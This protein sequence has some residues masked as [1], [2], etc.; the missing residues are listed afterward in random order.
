MSKIIVVY[1]KRYGKLTVGTNEI[2]KESDIKWLV[3]V[4]A[5]L[6]LFLFTMRWSLAQN[7]TINRFLVN[8]AVN[9]NS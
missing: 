2:Q 1:D 6:C 9:E 3:N 5:L 7:N 4:P 8:G